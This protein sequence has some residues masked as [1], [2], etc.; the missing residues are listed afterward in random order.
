[1]ESGI[2]DS[3]KVIMICTPNYLKKSNE[4]LGG[5]GVE[6]TIIT[7]EFYDKEK[8][9][10]YIPI[11]RNYKQNLHECLPTYLKSKYSIDFNKESEY[12]IK[13]DEL[14]RKILNIPRYKKP[15]LGELPKLE[16]NEI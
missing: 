1:M 7:G 9:N 6:N 11:V 8:V 3:D 12:K 2:R 4:R 10:K 5:V 15:Q 13:F 14:V 16:S